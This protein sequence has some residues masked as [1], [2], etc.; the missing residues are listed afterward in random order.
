MILFHR[1]VHGAQFDASLLER[2]SKSE[3]REKFRHAMGALR[4]HG[5]RKVMR[6]ARHVGDDFGLLWIRDARLEHADDCGQALT[7]VNGLAN[8]RRISIE[9]VRPEMISEGNDAGRLRA[10]I[11]RLDEASEH[12]TQAHDAEIGPV[13]HA[14]IDF[15]R[16]ADADHCEGDCGEIAKLAEVLDPLL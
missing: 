16:L 8:H 2:R 12:R 6:T 3:T 11:L 15:A 9:G 13:D 10:V 1:P 7:K 4:N 5:C 14:A